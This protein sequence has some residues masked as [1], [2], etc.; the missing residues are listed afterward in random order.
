M[1]TPSGDLTKNDGE[2]AEEM[3]R[4]FN[5][6]HVRETQTDELPT[7]NRGYNGDV[8]SNIVLN[9][10]KLM[11]KMKKLKTGKACGPEGVAYH[12]IY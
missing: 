7:P 6:V 5:G 11:K 12:L 3:N 9:R 4:A 10:N 2:T 1:K 8:E